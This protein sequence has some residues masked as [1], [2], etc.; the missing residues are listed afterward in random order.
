MKTVRLFGLGNV[1]SGDD[2]LGPFV[3]KILDAAYE[4]PA[5]VFLADIGT[6]GLA[7]SDFLL[8]GDMVILV[9]A[10]RGEGHPGEVLTYRGEEVYRRLSPERIGSH[11]P[12]LAEAFFAVNLRN[13]SPVDIVLI[14]VVPL[15]VE[16]G[17]GLST[18]VRAAAHKAAVAVIE[19]LAHLGVEVKPKMAPGEPDLWWERGL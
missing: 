2:A 19:E 4:F 9:D 15:R 12:A 7:M 10:V 1:L 8:G 16:A 11:E 5:E 17:I 13:C 14:G 18:P 6:P 3:I